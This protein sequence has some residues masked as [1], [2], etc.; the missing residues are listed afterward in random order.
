MSLNPKRLKK[1]NPLLLNWL[2]EKNKDFPLWK[3]PTKFEL[4]FFLDFS[5]IYNIASYSFILSENKNTLK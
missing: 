4:P 5:P 2:E 1:L 3:F